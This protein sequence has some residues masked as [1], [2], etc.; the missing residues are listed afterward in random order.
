MPDQ[1]TASNTGDIDRPSIR[2]VTA[3]VNAASGS[4]GPQAADALRQMLEGRDIEGTVL[5]PDPQQIEPM[6][7]Q[8]VESSPDLLIILAGDGTARLAATLCGP[9]GPLIA[10]LPGG[11]MNLLPHALYGNRSWQEALELAL[12]QGVERTVSGGA[13]GGHP[14]YCSAILGSPA[15]WAR[16]REAV[17]KR[18]IVEAW[19]RGAYALSRAFT[20]D[21]HYALDGG[22]RRTAESL[23]LI[24]PLISKVM[25]EEDALEVAALEMHSAGEVFRLAFNGLVSDWRRDPGVVDQLAQYGRVWARRSIPAILDGEMY[26]LE[27]GARFEFTPAA[28]RALAPPSTQTEASL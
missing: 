23:V 5:S 7:R 6:V 17:R 2:R 12:D 4:V 8:A 26:R 21:L 16:A 24:S 3:V 28:F 9:G 19:R 18:R 22:R 13:V 11:T 27:H 25:R 14:F 15:L 10:P 20:G 1:S